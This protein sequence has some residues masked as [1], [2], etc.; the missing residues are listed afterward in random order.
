M[1]RVCAKPQSTSTAELESALVSTLGP[2]L[3]Q[4]LVLDSTEHSHI[5]LWHTGSLPLVHHPSLRLL[6]MMS[7]QMLPPQLAGSLPVR[8]S[9]S[10]LY[11][12]QWR[13]GMDQGG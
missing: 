7:Q 2:T 4:L 8:P 5:M 12:W 9:S 11:T 13:N 10:A 1:S 3:P 6:P